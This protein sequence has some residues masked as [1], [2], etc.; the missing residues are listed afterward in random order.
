M[1]TGNINKKRNSNN[2][3]HF[4]AFSPAENTLIIHELQ[5]CFCFIGGIN[6]G[7]IIQSFITARYLTICSYNDN[8]SDA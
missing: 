6:P 2:S 4:Y 7:K 5:W 1:N 8:W 3:S